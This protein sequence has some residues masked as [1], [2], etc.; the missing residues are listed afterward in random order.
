MNK[1][2]L[3]EKV[4]EKRADEGGLSK[5]DAKAQVDAVLDTIEESLAEDHEEVPLGKVGKLAVVDQP[6]RNHRNPQNGETVHKPAHKK[7]KFKQS[8]SI[9]DLLNS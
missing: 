5:K 6:A 8:K 1:S 7:V 9:K 3:V 4:Y 2:E